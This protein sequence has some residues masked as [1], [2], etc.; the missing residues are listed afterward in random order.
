MEQHACR[1]IG[2]PQLR[3]PGART[4]G[5]WMNRRNSHRRS[6]ST[7]LCQWW[8]GS[9][10]RSG[11]SASVAR[12][13]GAM[14]ARTARARCT[15]GP[16]RVDMAGPCAEGQHARLARPLLGSGS[17][18]PARLIAVIALSGTLTSARADDCER[19]AIWRDGHAI[20]ELCRGEASEH[21]LV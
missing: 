15:A 4:R 1:C 17:V 10:D 14:T 12:G 21:E 7:E 16:T 5:S 8:M 2:D 18:H 20:G 19:I 9:E 3:G 6:V 11:A 13:M